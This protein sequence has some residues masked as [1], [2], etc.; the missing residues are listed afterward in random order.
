MSL[1]LGHFLKA[2]GFLEFQSQVEKT[3]PGLS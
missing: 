1:L 3:K 2:Y